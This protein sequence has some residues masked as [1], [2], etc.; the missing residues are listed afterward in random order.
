[1]PEIT[2]PLYVQYTGNNIRQ[3][4]CECIAF[5]QFEETA[6][7]IN[8]DKF[9]ISY[10]LGYCQGINC[11]EECYFILNAKSKEYVLHKDQ[12]GNWCGL[13]APEDYLCTGD[14]ISTS[15]ETIRF[16]SLDLQVLEDQV[17][18]IEKELNSPVEYDNF[19]WHYF[20][21]F[22]PGKNAQE[23]IRSINALISNM[24]DELKKPKTIKNN[25]YYLAVQKNI[26]D[27]KKI[28][29]TYRKESLTP[30]SD[31]NKSIQEFNSKF[32]KARNNQIRLRLLAEGIAIAKSDIAENQKLLRD[33][34]LQQQLAVIEEL[35][36][37]YEKYQD[38]TNTRNK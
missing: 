30:D 33:C 27:N 25:E 29:Q 3:G 37:R 5:G 32:I 11:K 28:L 12:Q 36:N 14:K 26:D 31:F 17:L 24:E 34:K 6:P 23:S 35:L 1:M 22:G 10:K 13:I 21:F 18:R 2:R 16:R 15:Y 4:C 7:T 38:F 9:G 8:T 19:T 20:K